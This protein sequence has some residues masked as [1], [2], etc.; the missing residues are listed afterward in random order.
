MAFY[1]MANNLSRSQLHT[2]LT[3][4]EGGV[5]GMLIPEILMGLCQWGSEKVPES[6]NKINKTYM[7]NN[8]E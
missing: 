8:I 4:P 3:W 5:V 2:I 7:Q 1:S 6:N